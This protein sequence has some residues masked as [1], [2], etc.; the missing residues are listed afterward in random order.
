[1][2]NICI[3]GCIGECS[4]ECNGVNGRLL[5]SKS[6]RCKAHYAAFS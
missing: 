3:G 5:F 4:A 1:M 6:L 2:G